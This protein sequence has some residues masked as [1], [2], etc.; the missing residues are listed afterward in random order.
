MTHELIIRR[1]RLGP[2]DLELIRELVLQEG[3]HGRTYL[4]RRLCRLWDWR[5][6][7]GRFREI[8]C[9]DLLRQLDARGWIRLPARLKPA[10][11]PGYQNVVSAPELPA[12]APPAGWP[13]DWPARVELRRVQSP[14]QWHLFKGLIGTYHYLGYQQPTGAQL[15]YLAFYERDPIAALSFGP[16]AWKIG[17]RDQFIGWSTPQREQRLPWLV[18]NERF[19]I[20][21]WVTLPQLASWLLSHGLRRLR[22]DWQQVYHHDLALCETFVDRERFGGRAYAAANWTCVGPTQ[23]RGRNDQRNQGGRP[24]KT[25]WLYPLR[26]DFRQVLCAATP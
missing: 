5:Q 9:R 23:G 8:A 24:V 16:A 7:N 14:P 4:S 11:R 25:I 20:L 17:P 19:L 18:N 10:R 12:Q 13:R 21:P 26:P 1:R 6:A 3:T 15:Q 22:R 2:E